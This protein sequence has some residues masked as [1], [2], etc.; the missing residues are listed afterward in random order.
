SCWSCWSRGT[1]LPL[2]LRCR[3]GPSCR[4]HGLCG[5]TG[6]GCWCGLGLW[7]C[8]RAWQRVE[9]QLVFH[10]QRHQYAMSLRVVPD[11]RRRLDA[12]QHLFEL[13]SRLA[14]VD[15]LGLPTRNQNRTVVGLDDAIERALRQVLGLLLLSVLG[16]VVEL[17]ALVGEHPSPVLIG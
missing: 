13:L 12:T 16:D 7:G 9:L 14:L 2:R 5:R 17:V 1:R 4:R 15:G 6:S 10:E 11:V 8:R 3:S